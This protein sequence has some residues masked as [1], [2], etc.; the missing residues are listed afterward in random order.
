[1]N[2]KELINAG[3]DIIYSFTKAIQLAGGDIS[4]FDLKNM[5]AYDLLSMLSTNNIEFKYRGKTK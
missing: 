4:L 3:M 5:N 2:N 1:M